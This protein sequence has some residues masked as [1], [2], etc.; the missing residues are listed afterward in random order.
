[1]G[2]TITNHDILIR[3]PAERLRAVEREFEV[4]LQDEATRLV[5][6]TRQGQDVS[7]RPFRPYTPA[8][9]RRK[10]AEGRNSS[11]PDLTF[12]GRMLAAVQ[13]RVERLAGRVVGTIFFNSV[14]EAVKARANQAT[15]PFFG[16]AGEQ[17]TRLTN[18]LRGA[19]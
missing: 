3:L 18:R 8:Y 12:T 15:R 17:I 5:L 1:M 4:A 11:P 2:I 10:R 9:A 13:T 14:A 6:R 7:G 19:R 16:L